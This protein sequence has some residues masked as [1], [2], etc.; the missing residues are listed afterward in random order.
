MAAC[1]LACVRFW[2]LSPLRRV[3]VVTLRTLLRS[4]ETVAL[5]G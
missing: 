4:A 5:N 3:S 2:P 1:V